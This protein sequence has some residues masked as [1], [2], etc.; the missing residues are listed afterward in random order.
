MSQSGSYF[1]SAIPPGM[2][3][4]TLTGNSGGAVGPDGANNINVLGSGFVDVTGNPGTNTL[5]ISLTGSFSENFVTDAGTA[6]PAAGIL[7]VLGGATSPETSEN[8]NTFADPNGSNNLRIALNNTIFW[9]DT[10]AGGTQGVL[11]LD[12]I[13][14]LHNFSS[15]TTGNVFIGKNAGNFTNAGGQAVGIGTG[16]LAALTTGSGTAVGPGV[17]SDLTSG[18][19]NSG[20]GPAAMAVLTTGDWNLSLATNSLWRLVS[21]HHNIVLGPNTFG[22]GNSNNRGADNYTS[23]ESANIIINNA[24]VTGESNTIRIGTQGVDVRSQNRAFMAG[25]YAT[26]PATNGAQPVVIDPDG[27]LGTVGSMSNGQVMIGFTGFDPVIANLIAGSG[28]TISNGPGT[29]TISSTGADLLAYTSVTTT[30]YVVLSTDEFLGVN[31]S[32]VPRTIQLPNAPSTGRVIYIK[33]STGNANTNN[34]SVTT[35]GG[36]VTID[37]VTT[38][39]MNTQ[40][41]SINVIFNGTS[42][43]V[44]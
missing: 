9:P 34:I 23:S 38:Y 17:L 13:R 11:Y 2:A 21:G 22:A 32:A 39:T 33:D 36:A 19:G 12:G 3:V 4:Q 18:T 29:I 14:W 27:Q 42:Y 37:G 40:Y 8:I 30:P 5:T 1:S 43:E 15:V 41:S 6:I 7:N 26:N 25:I 10:D 44:F 31:V 20:F 35:V 16:A 24:G 28:I